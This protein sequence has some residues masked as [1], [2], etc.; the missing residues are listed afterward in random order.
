MGN[1]CHI[2]ASQLKCKKKINLKSLKAATQ[3]VTTQMPSSPW[4]NLVSFK[5]SLR[6]NS[7]KLHPK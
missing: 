5:I 6:H 1:L 7:T 2:L 4:K 3:Q